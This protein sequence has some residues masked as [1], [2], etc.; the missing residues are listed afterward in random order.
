[1][2]NPTKANV[3][4][5]KRK[6]GTYAKQ[7]NLKV[8]CNFQDGEN[9]YVLNEDEFKKYCDADL[10]DK[11]VELKEQ[12]QNLQD[13]YAA[14]KLDTESIKQQMQ[15]EDKTIINELR[16]KL[17]DAESK[18]EKLQ[19][20][21]NQL[22]QDHA[23]ELKQL[24][25]RIQETNDKM[26][27]VEN[28]N[29]LIMQDVNRKNL[30][31]KDYQSEVDASIRNAVKE[32]DKMANAN[33]KEISKWDFLFHKDKINLN[34]QADEIIEDNTPA[35]KQGFFEVIT[36][37]QITNGDGDVEDNKKEDKEQ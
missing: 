5:Y 33:L 1:M 19:S 4:W 28:L 9:V 30:E 27:D 35:R 17:E 6:S 29:T 7:I 2:F 3:K 18:A 21:I 20:D 25:Q 36:A 12:L 37:P 16:Q 8:D 31:L 34:I 23:D 24:N 11:N 32:T 10:F 13:E 22:H 15:S 26:H 14:F